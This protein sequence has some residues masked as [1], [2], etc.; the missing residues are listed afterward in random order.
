LIPRVSCLRSDN[1][2]RT[3]CYRQPHKVNQVA[4]QQGDCSGTWFYHWGGLA[5]LLSLLEQQ[6][7]SSGRTTIERATSGTRAK[8]DDVGVGA[9]PPPAAWQVLNNTDFVGAFAYSSKPSLSIEDCAR[10]CLLRPNCVATAWNGPKSH[11]HNN[12]CNF[13]CE[14]TGQHTSVGEVGAIITKRNGSDLCAIPPAPP[15]PQ[16]P[17][18]P[19][20]VDWKSGVEAGWLLA[21]TNPPTDSDLCPTYGNGFVAAT[22]C[23]PTSGAMNT[24]GAF[25]SGFYAGSCASGSRPMKAS[26]NHRATVPKPHSFADI[27][28]ATYT[29]MALDLKGGSVVRRYVLPAQ[30]EV[31]LQYYAHRSIR[32]LLVLNVTATHFSSSGGSCRIAPVL[33][34]WATED[35]ACHVSSGGTTLCNMTS[36]PETSRQLPTSVA[37]VA[38]T[39]PSTIELTTASPSVTLVSAFATSLEPGLSADSIETTARQRWQ[40]AH[41]VQPPMIAK[42]HAAAWAKLWQADMAI[43]GNA[44]ATAALRSSMYYILSSVR[45]DWAY[46]SSPGG[47]PSTSYDGHVFWDCETWFFPPIAVLHPTI[48]RSL[49]A[50][51]QRML[52]EARRLAQLAEVPTFPKRYPGA[53]FPWQS[54]VTGAECS[55]GY[56]GQPL[57]WSAEAHITPDVVMAHRLLFR[58]NHNETWLRDDAWPLIEGACTFLAAFMELEPSSGNFTVLQ[59]IP[60]TEAGHVDHPAYTTASAALALAFCVDSASRLG[61]SIPANWSTIAARPFLPLNETLYPG[62]PVHQVYSPWNGGSLAQAGVALLQYPLGFPMDET[63]AQND[64]KF[65]K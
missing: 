30:C 18:P 65:C 41:S 62:G 16:P 8:S 45:D 29:G 61:L 49:T 31:E 57:Y 54:A 64:L 53:R 43:G 48:A 32:H 12:I 56:A 19:L 60:T 52:P 59:V 23:P 34:P 26:D 5:G 11:Y 39:L 13:V 17:P 4:G 15:P 3:C 33:P 27:H 47:L 40:A 44:T 63:L 55:P 2:T 10:Q 6:K 22:I 38:D 20:P 58:L 7:L 21:G 35:R 42:Q 50:Y 1:L 36:T 9:P 37:I 25:L 28:N 24:G 14:T 46:G 51:R